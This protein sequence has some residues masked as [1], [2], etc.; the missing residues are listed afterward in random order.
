MDI[1][2]KKQID[3]IIE[4]DK[5]KNIYRQ[6]YVLHENRK[7]NDSEHSWHLAL[8]A[9]VLKDY[10]NE[11]VDI[12]KVM[13][14]VLI[15][16]IVEIDAGDTYC[17]DK[18]GYETKRLRE[19]KAAERIFGILPETQRDEMR[20]LWEEFEAVDTAESKFAAALDRI[21]PVLLNIAKEG[22]SWKEH[23]ISYKQVYERNFPISKGSDKI[24]AYVD[25]LLK[26]CVEKGF[27]LK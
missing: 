8:M 21:Q 6:T 26:S 22:L 2:L 27:L 14:M 4:M 1:D 5:L 25:E 16:D 9:F 11:P 10:S 12:L 18:S 15:H 19:E 17:Y 24:W 7:E 20:A 13:K 23:G 3:F